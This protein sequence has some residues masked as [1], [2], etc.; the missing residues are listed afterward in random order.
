MTDVECV[1][2][3][4]LKEELLGGDPSKIPDIYFHVLASLGHLLAFPSK[5]TVSLSLPVGSA[6]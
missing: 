3:G 5:I 4:I 2:I 1:H 6:F